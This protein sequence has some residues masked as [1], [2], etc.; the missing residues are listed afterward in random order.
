MKY[1]KRK[2]A[3]K[4]ITGSIVDSTNID[5]KTKNTYSAEII[6]KTK[7]NKLTAGSNIT[8]A[9][10]VIS[11]KDTFEDHIRFFGGG[12][13]TKFTVTFEKQYAFAL[14][15]TNNGGIYVVNVSAT[16]ANVFNINGKTDLTITF[17]ADK[18]I[19]ITNTQYTRFS[20]ISGTNYT[21]TA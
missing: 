3:V 7:Q 1:I 21:I 20:I 19:A 12:N 11:A 17:V 4:P 5:D 18:K 2:S 15:F 8:I 16:T 10:N 13:S 6:D 14:L 9:D